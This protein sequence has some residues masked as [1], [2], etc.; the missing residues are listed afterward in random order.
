MVTFVDFVKVHSTRYW[1]VLF[2][3]SF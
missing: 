1:K 3:L 2:L